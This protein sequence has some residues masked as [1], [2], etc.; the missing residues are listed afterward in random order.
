VRTSAWFVVVLAVAARLV[1]ASCTAVDV[2]KVPGNPT[3]YE[4]LLVTGRLAGD[5]SQIKVWIPAAEHL[6][7]S[8]LPASAIASGTLDLACCDG[9][10]GPPCRIAAAATLTKVTIARA[11]RSDPH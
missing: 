2:S 3:A 1:V 8:A 10:P 4:G 7:C 5:K 6:A 9:D 11:K